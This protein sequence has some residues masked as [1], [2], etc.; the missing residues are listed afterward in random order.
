[1]ATGSQPVYLLWGCN[2]DSGDDSEEDV[3]RQE[4]GQT[5]FQIL[6]KRD[7]KLDDVGHDVPDV[8]GEAN[9]DLVHDLRTAQP[10]VINT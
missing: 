5:G 10:I 3:I 2:N 6:M 8:G 9:G 7:E 4:R 1:M